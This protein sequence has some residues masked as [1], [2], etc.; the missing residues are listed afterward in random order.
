MSFPRRRE[1]RKLMKKNYFVYMMASEKN[2]TLY[3]GMTNGLQKRVFQHK[4]GELDGFTK[5][6]NIK[7]LVYYEIF[8]NSLEA[9]IREKQLKGWNRK[10]KIR[11]IEK[12][13]PGWRD[14]FNDMI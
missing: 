14:L 9:I 11:L 7:N 2:G 8:E 3:I 10:W 4:E 13:N 5:K 6:Y 12:N 1:S